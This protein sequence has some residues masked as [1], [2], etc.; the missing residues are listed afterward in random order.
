MS[1]NM[2]AAAVRPANMRRPDRMPPTAAACPEAYS[3]VVPAK[4]AA[5][6]AKACAVSTAT[7]STATMSAASMSPATATV[8][9]ATTTPAA[10]AS[11]VRR[12]MI[13]AMQAQSRLQ[14]SV[15]PLALR[16][17][18]EALRARA[19]R[20]LNDRIMAAKQSQDAE[21][22]AAQLELLVRRVEELRDGAFTP[23]SQQPLVRAMLLP[24]GSFGGT[25]LLEYLLLPG[26]S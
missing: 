5:M 23:F 16:L 24:L 20:R 3:A 14:M 7:M 25:A 8:P 1:R 21:R 26:L 17:S 4:P 12:G 9:A 18:A 11:S 19:L 15:A 13:A 10:S 22:L 6:P 2:C